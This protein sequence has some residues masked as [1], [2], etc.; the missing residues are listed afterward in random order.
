MFLYK[1]KQILIKFFGCDLDFYRK[2]RACAQLD[3][4]Q[5]AAIVLLFFAV[6]GVAVLVA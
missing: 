4:F 3:A 1:A 6:V 2:L 5:R